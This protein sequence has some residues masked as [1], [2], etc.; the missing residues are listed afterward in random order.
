MIDINEINVGDRVEY[1]DGKTG[2]VKVIC[3]KIVD[4]VNQPA[5]EGVLM[6]ARFMVDLEGGGGR[7]HTHRKDGVS[8][9]AQAGDIVAIRK[10]AA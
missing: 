3:E 9:A 4:G 8:H 1:H 6:Q 10:E 7:Y 2:V 5:D